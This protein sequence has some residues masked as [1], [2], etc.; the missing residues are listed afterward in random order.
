M[1]IELLYIGDVVV[2]SEAMEDLK[3]DFGIGRMHWKVKV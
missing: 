1:V 2:M 3:V